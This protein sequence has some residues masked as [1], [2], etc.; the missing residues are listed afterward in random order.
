MTRSRFPPGN[1]RLRRADLR[2]GPAGVRMEQR[3]TATNRLRYF[4]IVNFVLLL[5]LNSAK[6]SFAVVFGFCNSRHSKWQRAFKPSIAIAN[7]FAIAIEAPKRMPK[8]SIQ[9]SK[10]GC[11]TLTLHGFHHFCAYALVDATRQWA[12]K[13]A[14]CT[15]FGQQSFLLWLDLTLK[16]HWLHSVILTSKLVN[17]AFVLHNT[18]SISFAQTNF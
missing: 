17:A 8:A 16:R 18:R 14:H 13:H 11:A 10:L 1:I 3:D 9:P 5:R 15:R 6:A 12:Y 4:A 7:V 2:V